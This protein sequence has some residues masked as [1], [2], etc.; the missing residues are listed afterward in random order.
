MSKYRNSTTETDAPVTVTDAPPTVDAGSNGTA[1][2]PKE[3]PRSRFIRLHGKR[4]EAAVKRIGHVANMGN[5]ASYESSDS[6]REAIITVIQES[7]DEMKRTLRRT[8]AAKKSF[9]LFS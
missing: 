9:Q 4:L 7:V 2:K 5:K 8:S 6:E 1:A 3:T